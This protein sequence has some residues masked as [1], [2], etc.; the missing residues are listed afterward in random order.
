MKICTD[1][2]N[3]LTKIV[4][5]SQKFLKNRLIL[6]FL[7]AFKLPSYSVI[8]KRNVTFQKEDVVREEEVLEEKM[9]PLLSSF[10]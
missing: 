8:K 7:Q 4:P 5:S 3:F 10:A 9:L 6:V 1:C 2:W